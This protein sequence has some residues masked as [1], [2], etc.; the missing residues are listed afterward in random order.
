MKETLTI[1]GVDLGRR[2][3]KTAISVI[4]RTYVRTGELF[5]AAHYDQD[6]GRR[7]LDA[8]ERVTVE[9]H[10]RHLERHGPGVRYS[11]VA[12]RVA[13]IVVSLGDVILVVDLT[14]T[15]RPVYDLIRAELSK[16]LDDDVRVKPCLVAVSGAAGGVSKSPDTGWLVPRR[17]LVSVALVLLEQQRLKIAEGLRL[18]AVLQDEILAFKPKLDKQGEELEVWR[19]RP[20][21]DLVLAVAVS[22]WAAE[23]FLLK[24]ESVSAGGLGIPRAAT[25]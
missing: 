22:V 4:E 19:E 6:R 16:T 14:A 10:V 23:R 20:H 5:S 1:V 25:A 3:E 18:A 7:G 24:E 17:D 9:Y 12:V 15:G 21:D 13:E 8:R 11:K 2:H